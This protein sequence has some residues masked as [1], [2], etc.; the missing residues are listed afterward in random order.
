MTDAQIGEDAQDVTLSEEQVV[1]EK[2]VVPKERV[3]IDTDVVTDQREV[4]E[5]LRDG[6]RARDPEVFV[7]PTGRESPS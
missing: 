5:D 4:S 2:R 3:R 6:R 1:V 7:F